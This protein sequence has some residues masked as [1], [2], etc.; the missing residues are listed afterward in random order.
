MIIARL[1]LGLRAT[2]LCVPLFAAAGCASPE[3]GAPATSTAATTLDRLLTAAHEQGISANVSTQLKYKRPIDRLPAVSLADAEA[4]AAVATALLDTL[5]TVKR[6]E[7]S[8]AQE[9]SAEVLEWSLQGEID[10]PK[11]YWLTMRA[12][13]PYQSP[14]MG[15]LLFMGRDIPL[16]TP[17]AQARYLARLTDIGALIDSIRAGVDARAARGI[18]LPKPE[19]KQIVGALSAIKVAGSKSPYAPPATRIAALSDSVRPAFVAA[20]TKTVDG[21]INPALGRLIDF[22]GGDYL[23]AAPD[24]VGLKQYPGGEEYYRYLVS[25]STTLDIKPEAIHETGLAYLAK[26]EA[27]MDSLLKVIGFKGSRKEFQAAMGRDPRFVA[28]TPEDVG[29]RYQKY[30]DAIKPLI[31][32]LFSREPKASA[33]F[34]RLNPALEGSQTYGFYQAPNPASPIGVYFYNASNLA[35]RSLFSVAP[36]AYHELVPGHHFQ[37]SLAQENPDLPL[38]RRDFYATAFGE[39]WADYASEL[40]L[41]LGLYADPYDR[42]G[43]LISEAF[44]TTRLVVDPGMNLLGWS[45]EKAMD[46]MREHTMMA[47]SEIAS[48]SLRYSVDLPAQ[49]LG[50]KVGAMEFWRLRAKAQQELGPKFDVRAFHA[51]ILD[52]GELPM[53]VV[54]KM[55]DRWTQESKTGAR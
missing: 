14:L 24:Q 27:S 12:I 31:P 15:D 17:E 50:Y 53:T 2:A 16:D 13:T 32:K 38:L 48:E 37:I 36:I 54:G 25:R 41:E 49:A 55:V 40:P 6:A 1:R 28:K 5:A 22:I 26:L 8:P 18:R 23:K 44:L 9:I 43:R 21:T 10:G 11:Y 42:Y 52:A 47:E 29:A 51:L 7:L 46:F 35:H 39:G 45:R 19:I 30:Y 20:V 4:R 34:R 3:K 33:E